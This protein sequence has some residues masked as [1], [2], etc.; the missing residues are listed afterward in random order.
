MNFFKKLFFASFF[1]PFQFLMAQ[2]YERPIVLLITSYNN[3]SWY[4]KNLDSAFCQ[5]YKNFRIIYVDD[6]STDGTGDLVEKYIQERGWQD[7]VIL[8]K[9]EIR[10]MKMENFYQAVHSFCQDNEIVVDFDGDDWLANEYVLSII[11]SAYADLKVWITYGTY[12]TWPVSDSCWCADLP[13]SVIENSSYRNYRWVTS[14]LRT[15][16]A[17]LFKKIK[18]K[19]L[20]VDGVFFE[21]TADL[22]YM[23]PMLEMAGGRIKYIKDILYIY[24]RANP[25]NDNKIDRERQAFLDRYIRLL[26]KY[27]KLTTLNL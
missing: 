7:H 10:K 14:Q 19:D 6:C 18:K 1:F 12:I 11:N 25:I 4:K 24:N 23:F 5:Q 17:G 27:E 8:V 22:G 15:F 21:R 26:S 16:Y 13:K 20:Q 2:Q 3:S 9:N